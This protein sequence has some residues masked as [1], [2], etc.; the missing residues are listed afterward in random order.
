MDSLS[1]LAPNLTPVAALLG[2][3]KGN[4]AGSYPTIDDFSYTE[5]ITFTDVGK[6]FLHYVQRTWSPT[7]APMHTETGYLRVPDVGRVEFVLS[8]PTGQT[9]LCEGSIVADAD[10]LVLELH[11]RVHNSASAKQV[12]TTLRRYEMNGDLITATFA[13]A[14]VGQPLTHHLRSELRRF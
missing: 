12:D 1:A 10:T 13:M 3:W 14:A 4:G 7:G 6:P 11:S 2:T 5:E 9:E 8:Q